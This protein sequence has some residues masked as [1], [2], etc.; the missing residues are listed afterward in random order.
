MWFWADEH[1]KL[2]NDATVDDAEILGPTLGDDNILDTTDG[3]DKGV[4][5]AGKDVE[6]PRTEESEVWQ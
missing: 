2:D 1:D 5:A 4:I 6:F 3:D